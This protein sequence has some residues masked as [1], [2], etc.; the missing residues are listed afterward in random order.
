MDST[1]RLGH[2]MAA[3][4]TPWQAG[5]AP[6]GGGSSGGIDVGGLERLVERVVS[7]G[8]DGI[9]PAGSTGEG[10]LLTRSQRVDLTAR[11]RRLTPAGL[12]VIPGLPL[13]ALT[14][15]PAE[16]D[17][18]AAAGADAALVAPPSYYPLSDD[19]VRRLYATLAENSPLPLV[20]YNIPVFT[21]V[22]L[23]P[24]VVGFL[25]THPAVIGIKDSSRDME[26]QQEVLTATA[27]SRDGFA[28][29]TGTDSLLV[30]SLTIGAAGTIAASMNLV[31]ELPSG[32]YRAFAAG[33]VA[34]ATRLQQRLAGIVGVCR[35]GLFP[36]GWKAALEVA[37]VCERIAVP[38]GTSL[39]AE[40]FEQLSARL[41]TEELLGGPTRTG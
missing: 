35:R 31:P 30:A 36:A 10:A 24:A 9:S 27:A 23:S 6:S 25:A 14:D 21:K 39:S 20:L 22:R 1:P 28:V 19:A 3:L 4:A 29:L 41:T 13:S 2:T 37:G 8:A 7:G 38:P 33:D 12:P 26:Y 11:V 15:G 18:L 32:I 34:T 17:A 40:E 5:A 16:L